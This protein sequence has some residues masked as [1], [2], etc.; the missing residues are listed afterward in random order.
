MPP[1]RRA[2]RLFRSLERRAVVVCLLFLVVGI[3][4]GAISARLELRTDL[5]ELLPADHPAVVALRTV[6]PRQRSASNLVMLVEGPDPAAAARFVDALRPHL[7]ALRPKT[8]TAIDWGPD[9]EPAQ[10]AARWGWLYADLADLENIEG[11]LDR[12]IASRTDPLYVDLEDT[13]PQKELEALAERMQKRAPKKNTNTR[14]TSEDGKT[15][16]VRMWRRRDGLGGSGDHQTIAA[17]RAAVERTRLDDKTPGIV[18]RMTGPIAQAVEEQAAIKDDLGFATV[19][20][21]ALVLLALWLTFGNL[22]LVAAALFPTLFGL[23]VALSVA[24]LALGSLNLNTAFLISIILGN[25]INAPIMVLAE[26]RRL[27]EQGL[28]TR[29]AL[30]RALLRSARGVAAAMLAAAAAYGVLGVTRFAGFRQFGLIGGVGMVSVLLATYVILPAML[31]WVE[32]RRPGSLARGRDRFSPPVLWALRKLSAPRVAA[33]IVTGVTI[34]SV[35]GVVQFATDPFE[36]NLR[37]LRSTQSEAGR[38]WPKMEALGM[39]SVGAGYI[40]NTAVMLVDDPRLADKVANA[41][42]EHDRAGEKLLGEVR[43]INTFLPKQQSEKLVVLERLRGRVDQ[44]LG[45][46]RKILAAA[47]VKRLEEARPPD[48]L[49]VIT[50]DDLPRVL[51][52]AFTEIDGTR[53]R[54][55]GVDADGKRYRDWDGKILLRLSK[56]LAVDVD[57]KRYVA[58]SAATVFA[59]I[60]ETLIADAPK[61]SLFALVVVS[62]LLVVGFGRR[63]PFVLASLGLGLLWLA[64]LAGLFGLR[65]NFMSF[66]AI[67]ISIGVGA[68]YSANLWAR[69]QDSHGAAVTPVSATVVLCSLTTIIG[70]STLILGRNGALRSFGIL[71]DLGEVTCLLAAMLAM[72]LLRRR[73]AHPLRPLGS[74]QEDPPNG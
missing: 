55:V 31:L 18:V 6:S 20:C 66:A 14:F 2:A 39:G 57:G 63:S 32:R 34:A 73:P 72:A 35:V 65:L 3:G 49:R 43:T 29:R 59:G 36:W 41:L 70:Y 58:A 30:P 40:A 50:T 54:L 47:D 61:L 69:E 13:D 44:L 8:L 10:F 22:G 42:W 7:E 5:T 51:L 68:D 64:G 16:G 21:V 33:T 48:G 62:A 53:G 25:G 17:V 9:Q 11:L 74:A 71:S 52:D 28:S 27:Y 24:A 23:L 12:L 45:K 56:S 4:L 67:P 15:I 19:V 38:L 60:L 37:K 26:L 46:H 1:L